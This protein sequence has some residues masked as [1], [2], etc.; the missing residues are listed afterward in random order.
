M[1]KKKE[2]PDLDKNSNN[3]VALFTKI[4]TINYACKRKLTVFFLFT[5]I[6]MRI[7]ACKIC[8]NSP[9]F[10]TLSYVLKVVYYLRLTCQYTINTNN[11]VKWDNNMY[12]IF[13]VL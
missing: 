10:L 12:Y 11:Y 5:K 2:W 3:P 9:T 13:V 7:L 4:L 8:R 6:L 1:K